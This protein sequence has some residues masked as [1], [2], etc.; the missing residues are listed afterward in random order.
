MM[1]DDLGLFDS[2][3]LVSA[4]PKAWQ[5][6]NATSDGPRPSFDFIKLVRNEETLSLAPFFQV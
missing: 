5:F 2:T 1:K 6:I 3:S 4:D